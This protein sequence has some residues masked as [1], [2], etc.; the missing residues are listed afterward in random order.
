[1]EDSNTARRDVS[2]VLEKILENLVT[3][4]HNISADSYLTDLGLDSLDRVEIVM[5]A[6]EE[7]N[8]YI[9]DG[10]LEHAET[11]GDVVS[12]ISKIYNEQV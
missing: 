5:E 8:I 7:L 6:E 1:M 2:F 3:S 11:V 9:D 10:A 12:I 4:K